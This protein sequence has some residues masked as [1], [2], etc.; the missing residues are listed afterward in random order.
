[1]RVRELWVGN[2]P[3]GATK[4]MVYSHFFIFG[5]IEAVELN[6]QNKQYPFYALVRFKLISCA[7]RAFDSTL[8]LEIMGSKVKV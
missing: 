2:L 3:E 8:C 1:M 7:K 4:E 6:R 5:E